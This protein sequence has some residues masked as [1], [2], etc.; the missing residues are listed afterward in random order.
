MLFESSSTEP[1]VRS[2]TSADFN[3]NV[4]GSRNTNVWNKCFFQP[5]WEITRESAC[6]CKVTVSCSNDCSL[7]LAGGSGRSHSYCCCFFFLFDF[8]VNVL[9]WHMY[10]F[11]NWFVEVRAWFLQFVI[12]NKFE[13]CTGMSLLTI[14]IWLEWPVLKMHFI[15]YFDHVSVVCFAIS[16]QV[17][18]LV[19]EL[20]TNTRGDLLC[21]KRDMKML[22]CMTLCICKKTLEPVL[23]P[24]SAPASCL[25]LHRSLP[26]CWSASEIPLL[27][28]HVLRCAS[29]PFPL[30]FSGKERQPAVFLVFIEQEVEW[31]GRPG[32][33]FRHRGSGARLGP[34]AHCSLSGNC[35]GLFLLLLLN[36]VWHCVSPPARVRVRVI[37]TQS[38][39]VKKEIADPLFQQRLFA[40]FDPTVIKIAFFLE[41][42]A[43]VSPTEANNVQCEGAR[44]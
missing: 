37:A 31:T 21:T 28:R 27:R 42:G 17:K 33:V 29:L 32:S 36:S 1:A 24:E 30:V 25:V 20:T 40:S 6:F 9:S 13:I 4:M 43:A 7:C 19:R 15:V 39:G 5:H 26:V 10:H 35:R 12:K 2:Q 18:N 22:T 3:L 8:T 14:V 44:G 16:S 41:A 34:G 38:H 11:T 23:W